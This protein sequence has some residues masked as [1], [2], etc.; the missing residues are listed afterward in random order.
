[1]VW[2]VFIGVVYTL[3][4]RPLMALFTDEPEVLRLGT[5]LLMIAAGYQFFD[6]MYITYAHALRGA[7]DTLVPALVTGTLCWGMLIGGGS[8]M[9]WLVPSWGVFGPWVIACVYGVVL[10]LYMVWRF[11]F[12]QWQ[13][14]RPVGF[15]ALPAQATMPQPALG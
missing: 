11:H 8:L 15:E 10:G 7:G 2:L 12:G 4:P 3:F 14:E 6:A 5:T 1:M 9:A 13:R